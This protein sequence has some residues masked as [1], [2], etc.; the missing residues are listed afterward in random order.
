[1]VSPP[2]VGNWK[3]LK[4]ESLCCIPSHCNN[5]LTGK[6]FL[7]HIIF[8]VADFC[9]FSVDTGERLQKKKPIVAILFKVYKI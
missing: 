8:Y 3:L 2:A 5:D 7:K 9:L 4:L 1:M 6:G